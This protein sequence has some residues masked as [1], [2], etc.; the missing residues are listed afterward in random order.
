MQTIA[1]HIVTN[2][3]GDSLLLLAVVAAI[4]SIFLYFIYKVI[5]EKKKID[6]KHTD[7]MAQFH[8]AI[9]RHF[10][11]HETREKWQRE[12]EEAVQRKLGEHDR[13]LEK[14]E[15]NISNHHTR[16]KLLETAKETL[17]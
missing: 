6:E 3:D 11:E 16:L 4:P 10:A 2:L 12:R 14:N 7:A 8:D 1:T 15:K 17:K 5:K 9:V 13:R